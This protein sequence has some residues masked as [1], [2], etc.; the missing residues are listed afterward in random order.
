MPVGP[1][2]VK[3]K[4]WVKDPRVEGGGYW[5]YRY[6]AVF[7]PSVEKTEKVKYVSVNTARESDR[8]VDTT[9]EEAITEEKETITKLTD[10]IKEFGRKRGYKVDSITNL[11]LLQKQEPEV[12]KKI[13]TAFVELWKKRIGNRMVVYSPVLYNPKTGKIRTVP[14]LPT[15]AIFGDKVRWW[16]SLVE[17][18]DDLRERR[19]E[20]FSIKEK[21]EIPVIAGFL[22][23]VNK[24]SKK[25][26]ET[27]LGFPLS[28]TDEG[29]LGRK[30]RFHTEDF[31][32]TEHMFPGVKKVVVIKVV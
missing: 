29:K 2:L 11:Y 28:F 12:Q 32:T 30:L 24:I 18:N 7:P 9:I 1:G 23:D 31:Y 8:I 17:A 3:K 26:I 15:H 27:M 20:F 21:D 4:V 5:A 10:E 25:D 6:T 22:V 16:L 14:T 19:S 13:L